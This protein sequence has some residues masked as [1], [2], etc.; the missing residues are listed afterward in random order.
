MSETSSFAKALNDFGCS[1]DKIIDML[2]DTSITAT[3]AIPPSDFVWTTTAS[4]VVPTKSYTCPCC[5]TH[6]IA[7]DPGF[8][9]NCHNCGSVMRCDDL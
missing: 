2:T 6:Y 9:P 5:G 4:S 8:I 3:I 1:S 7:R